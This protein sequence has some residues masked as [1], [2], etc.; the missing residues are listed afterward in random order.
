MRIV[1]TY[2]C[3]DMY[4][5]YKDVQ[6]IIQSA[7]NHSLPLESLDVIAIAIYLMVIFHVLIPSIFLYNTI[8]TMIV[9]VYVV[10]RVWPRIL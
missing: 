5:N 7:G 10:W 2:A 8:Q 3:A 6:D 9:P 1:Y 4:V